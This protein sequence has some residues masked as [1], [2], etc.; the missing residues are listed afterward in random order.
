MKKRLLMLAWIAL[1]VSALA[2]AAAAEAP[3]RIVL[4]PAQSEGGKPLLQ[5][6]KERASIR[7]YA[8]KSVPLPV[9]STLL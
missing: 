8:P 6:L 1:Y 9:L 4:P 3:R 7:E 5:A 2:S